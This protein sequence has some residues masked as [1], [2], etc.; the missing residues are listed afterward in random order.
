MIPGSIL[1][2]GIEQSLPHVLQN[3]T[4]TAR[5]P[6]SYVTGSPEMVT[7]SDLNAIQPTIGAPALRRQS[8][9]WHS[10]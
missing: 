1:G 9:Q 4:P 6:D 5:R 8:P 10:A 2:I 7:C 3:R